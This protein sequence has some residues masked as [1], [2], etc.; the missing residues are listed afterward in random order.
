MKG[1][2]RVSAQVEDF[3]KSLAPKPRRRIRL[4]IKG[5][6]QGRGDIKRLEGSLQPFS[7]LRVAG[8]RIIYAERTE[9]GMRVVDCVFAEAR[10][11]VYELFIKLLSEDAMT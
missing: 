1:K 3:I 8:Y 10:P 7:R 2:I 6:D 9:R 5:L 11:L 4:A